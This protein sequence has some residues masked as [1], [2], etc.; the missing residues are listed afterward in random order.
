MY[1]YLHE[2]IYKDTATNTTHTYMINTHIH[3]FFLCVCR[4]TF[5]L[6]TRQIVRT[7]SARSI[8]WRHSSRPLEKKSCWNCCRQRIR[9]IHTY[10]HTYIPYLKQSID[11]FF[12]NGRLKSCYSYL[13]EFA[14][15]YTYMHTY[16]H[17]HI[18]TFPI[19]AK[20]ILSCRKAR[21]YFM[22]WSTY[23]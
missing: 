12:I 8:R 6:W 20:M 7:M 16:I 14:F 3:T 13:I 1:A 2:Y 23:A 22:A 18:D 11:T 15:S 19:H 9:H 4:L 17:I 5:S 10:I 21:I